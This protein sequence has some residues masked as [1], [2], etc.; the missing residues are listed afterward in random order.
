MN[1]KIENNFLDITNYPSIERH[2]EKMASKGWLIKR[3][4]QGNIFIYKRI[5]PEILDFSITPYEI[6]TS[7]TKK[8]KEEVEEFNSVCKSVG[9]NYATKSYDLHIYFKEHGTEAM[10][11]QTDEEEEFKTLEFIGKKHIKSYYILIPFL[12]FVSWLAL[13][14]LF[15]SVSAM[16][17]GIAQ[18]AV[19]LIPA[20]IILSILS[21]INIRRFLKINRK[22]M[23][24][25]KSIEYSDSKFYFTRIVFSL[26]D[27]AL[28]IGIIY[29]FYV[30][31]FL[32]NKFMLVGLIPVLIGTIV[33]VIYRIFI[34]PA[35]IT[36]KYK[37][38]GFVAS[39]VVSAIFSII[40]FG[41]SIMNIINGDN[42]KN[43][44]IID[45]YKVLSI[46]DFRNE[47]LEDD[48]E[49][50]EQTSILI[51]KSYEYYSYCKGYGSVRTEY[52]KVLTE[53]LANNLVDRYRRQAE[54]ALTGRYSRQIELYLEE[55]VFDDYLLSKGL[56]KED[57]SS[58][59]GKEIKDAT[60]AAHNIINERSI[61]EDIENLWELDEVYFLNYEKTE[62]VIR[63]G[64]EVFYLEGLDFSDDEIIKIV[65]DKLNLS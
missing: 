20:G 42:H 52:S 3:I 4:I 38:I 46:N 35:K 50:I 47:T 63:N 25:G 37:K 14:R 55:G 19:P 24:L 6:E 58:L 34:K 31:M 17:D 33:G 9:W 16:K 10:D 28:I 7:F 44:Q 21:L 53:R 8:S 49:L 54:N 43:N 61:V 64:K 36:L 26:I 29:I 45:G 65:K 40:V 22:N 48:G 32:K 27:I 2:L 15:T 51:P 13:G 5:R 60:R 57:L 12:L 18:I 56:T 59:E 41:S 23:E 11:I 62:I 1:F 39:L 30:T